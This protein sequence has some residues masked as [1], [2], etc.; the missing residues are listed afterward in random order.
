[1]VVTNRQPRIPASRSFARTGALSPRLACWFATS[2]WDEGVVG[3]PPAGRSRF[4]SLGGP[5]P[6]S[7]RGLRAPPGASAIARPLPDRRDPACTPRQRRDRSH[8]ASAP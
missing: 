6:G 2:R 4:L 3:A 7:L 8:E 5:L 1:M